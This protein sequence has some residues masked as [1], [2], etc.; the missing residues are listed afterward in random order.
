M[1]R[2]RKIESVDVRASEAQQPPGAITPAIGAWTD[3]PPL[4]P[5][6]PLQG[7]GLSLSEQLVRD[8][9]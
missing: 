1:A 5:P 7:Q 3:G 6:I 9:R 2:T 4:P 8:R